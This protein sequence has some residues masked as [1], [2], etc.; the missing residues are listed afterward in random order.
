LLLTA[1]AL[2]LV[3]LGGKFLWASYVTRGEQAVEPDR[4]LLSLKERL[5]GDGRPVPSLFPPPPEAETPSGEEPVVGL[6][7]ANTEEELL[8]SP[9]T[10]PEDLPP[11]LQEDLR[12]IEEWDDGRGIPPELFEELEAGRTLLGEASEAIEEMALQQAIA[13]QLA[14]EKYLATAEEIP[15]PDAEELARMRDEAENQPSPEEKARLWRER[16]N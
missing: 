12:L 11:R 15:M 10:A 13:T 2:V 16:G 1:L 9:P 8:A 14:Y 3:S 6:P 5:S 4:D 7:H